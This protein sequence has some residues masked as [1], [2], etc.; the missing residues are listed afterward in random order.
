MHLRHTP[1]DDGTAS[2]FCGLVVPIVETSLLVLTIGGQMCDRCH[3]AWVEALAGIPLLDPE[4]V[5]LLPL[6]ED[7]DE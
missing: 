3:Q 7:D 1:Q 4:N 2:T 6:F 5:S